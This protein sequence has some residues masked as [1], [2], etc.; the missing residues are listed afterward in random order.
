MN[1]REIVKNYLERGFTW[2]LNKI[3]LKYHSWG[4]MRFFTRGL[5]GFYW[6]RTVSN[7]DNP[8]F[9][10]MYYRDTESE[11]RTPLGLIEKKLERR[12]SSFF[13]PGCN[14]GSNLVTIAKIYGFDKT[15]RYFGCDI[16]E[17]AIRDIQK[18]DLGG[19]GNFVLADIADLRF[20]R[21]IPDNSYDVIFTRDVFMFIQPGRLK[22]D[23]I[24]EFIRI[25]N[26]CI[27]L[28]EPWKGKDRAIYMKAHLFYYED[29]RKY[30]PKE[31]VRLEEIQGLDRQVLIVKKCF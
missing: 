18:I 3:P 27:L 8:N 26:G 30:L 12:P 28:M 5:M 22:Q 13:E 1:L 21:G 16:N 4:I 24:R 11:F 19:R 7:P 14:V 17:L 9:Y 25:S 23:I 6:R 29:M 20:L 2:F 31:S 15:I 10:K